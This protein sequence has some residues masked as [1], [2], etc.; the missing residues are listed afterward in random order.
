MESLLA[1][2]SSVGNAVPYWK[3]SDNS[4]WFVSPAECE[5]IAAG[6]ERRLDNEPQTLRPKNWP[7]GRPLDGYVALLREWVAF[8]RLAS[9]H[10]GYRVR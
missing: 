1:T 8:N 10:G 9:T 5:I 4:G 7:E 6:L 3:F 2:P